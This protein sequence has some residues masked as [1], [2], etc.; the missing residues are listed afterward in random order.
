MKTLALD[1]RFGVRTL[2]RSRGFAATAAVVFAL[3]I[4][5]STAMV[6]FIDPVLLQPLDSPHPEQLV[7]IRD[8][9]GSARAAASGAGIT[10]TGPAFLALRQETRAFSNVAAVAGYGKEFNLTGG[11]RPE[12]IRASSATSNYFEMLGVLP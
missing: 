3:G 10:G 12:R 9:S 1:I 2:W 8:T 7:A 11:D 5:G 6:S 4:G